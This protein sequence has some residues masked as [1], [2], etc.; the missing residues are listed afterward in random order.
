VWLPTG[1]R[2]VEAAAILESGGIVAR[3]F[4]PEGIRVSIGEPESVETLLR[5]A[6]EVVGT[7]RETPENAGLG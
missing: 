3:V 4:P 6:S 1:E 7:L 2:T 5:A